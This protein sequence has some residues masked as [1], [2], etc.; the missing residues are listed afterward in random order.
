MKDFTEELEND[1]KYMKS[2]KKVLLKDVSVLIS[3]HYFPHR[4][5]SQIISRIQTQTKKYLMSTN[6]INVYHRTGKLPPFQLDA[7]SVSELGIRAPVDRD[8]YSLPKTW[9]PIADKMVRYLLF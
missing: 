6:P 3:R 7:I 4:N 2:N 5:P 9:R 1:E 8:I